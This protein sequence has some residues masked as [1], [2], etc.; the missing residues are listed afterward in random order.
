MQEFHQLVQDVSS[1]LWGIPT[2]FLLVGVGIFI[3]FITAF[4]QIRRFGYS[5]SLISGK[6]DDPDDPG[7]ISHL[8]AL[9]ASLSATIGVGNIAGVGTAIAM[10]GPGAIVWMWITAI[11]GMGLKYGECLLSLK[12][13]V[14][15]KNGSVS[16]GP[17]YYLERGLKQKW[18][19]VLFALFAAI[20][21]LGI[22]NM[23]QANSVAE[24]FADYFHVPKVATG[25]VL[26]FLVFLVIIGGIKRIAQVASKMVPIMALYYIIGAIVVI[27]ANFDQI[28]LAF[29][30][31]F[32]D[33]FSG[34][35]ATG[36]FTGAALAQTIRFGVARGVFSNE[37]GLGSSP[38]A[39][40]AAKTKEPVREGLVAMLGPFIDTIVVCTMTAL[41]IILTG[42]YT[43]GATGASLTT[44]AFEMGLPGPGG[45]TVAIGIVFFALSTIITW[46]YYG[47]RC[48]AYLLG[49]KL[50][51][52]YRFLYCFLIP[53]GAAL[54]LPTVWAIGDIMNAMMIWPNLI[55]I[56]FLSPVIFRETRSYFSD[57]ARVY[58]D[59]YA[60]K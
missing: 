32:H 21:S 48:V 49:E 4:I 39:H 20:A 33:A 15:N 56:I 41:V 51:V 13:R 10:G 29:Q 18:L 38:I 44:T 2:I 40:G 6:F 22:G 17:M 43:T 7:E 14:I 52:P 46:S 58:P 59:I 3:S 31:I 47:D 27:V 23:I 5:W 26:G 35:A 50:V 12:Y 37:A 1:A 19:G 11:F 8:Q 55:G 42:A 36:G 28:G 60:N 45:A 57:P 34:T 25:L 30:I 24:P 9:N 54:E 16:A 53:V